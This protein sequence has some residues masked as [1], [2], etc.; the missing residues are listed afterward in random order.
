[1]AYSDQQITD[2]ARQLANK[3]ATPAEIESFVASARQPERTSATTSTAPVPSTRTS[4][5]TATMTQTTGGAVSALGQ[6]AVDAGLEGGGAALGQTIG[7]FG[8]PLDPVTIPLGGAIGGMAGNY[9]GQQR[10]MAMGQQPQGFRLGQFLGA[11]VTGG[12]PGGPLFG[13][14]RPTLAREAAKYAI[15]GLTAKAV[16][17]TVDDK[18]IMTPAEAMQA[19]A[20]GAAAPIVGSAFDKGVDAARIVTKQIQNSVRDATL[21]AARQAGYVIPASRVNPGPINNLLESF[22]GKA[23][24]LQEA[25]VRNQEITNALARKA[26]GLPVSA[27]ITESALA[28]VRQQAAA[29]YREIESLARQ[30]E[31]DLDALKKSR[32]TAADP[33]ELAVQMA[34]PATVKEASSLAIKAGADVNALKKA[35]F[36]ATSNYQFYSRSGDPKALDTARKAESLANDLEDKIESSARELGKP[37][38]ADELK[39]ARVKI[40][41]AYEVEKALNLGDANVSAPILGRSIDKGT[42]LTGELKTIAKFQQAAPSVM[43]EGA[44]VPASGVSKMRMFS[45]MGLG[46][47][48]YGML[49]PKGMM[50]AAIPLMEGPVRSGILSRAGQAVLAKPAYGVPQADFLARWG[51]NST[52]AAG[53]TNPFLQFLSEAYPAQPQPQ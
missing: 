35:R 37:E 36:D 6:A 39:A 32:F 48:G 16:E 19:A 15:G 41:K 20:L 9:I 28:Q 29:P 27:P 24:T 53:Q 10:R 14:A 2:L 26:V 8:G 45:A 22:A 1:M 25:A 51:R 46:G 21:A 50:A 38:L 34:D 18:R 17:T 49:G 7:A 42:P 44:S 23:A 47:A 31:S 4:G 5:P 40:A 43:R 33:H 13:A 12:I 11:G 3:G 30:A 52:A